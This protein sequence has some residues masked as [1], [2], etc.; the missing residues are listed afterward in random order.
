LI[1]S[2]DAVDRHDR[3]LGRNPVVDRSAQMLTVL[4]LLSALLANM[5]NGL[6]RQESAHHNDDYAN[7]DSACASILKVRVWAPATSWPPNDIAT[8]NRS[9]TFE[10][11]K[12]R[13]R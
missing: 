6:H 4:T 11:N 7:R 9:H 13:N 10:Y 8:S 3:V 2:A 1:I 5:Q 12:E